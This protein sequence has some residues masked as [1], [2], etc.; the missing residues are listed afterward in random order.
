MALPP[1]YALMAAQPAA[2]PW[3]SSKQLA[4]PPPMPVAPP[5]GAVPP[6]A[7]PRVDPAAPAAGS[8]RTFTQADIDEIRRRGGNADHLVAGQP[9]AVTPAYTPGFQENVANLG[10]MPMNQQI[11]ENFIQNIRAR[12]AANAAAQVVFDYDPATGQMRPKNNYQLNPLGSQYDPNQWGSNN[13]LM[14]AAGANY[15]QGQGNKT[16]LPN[17]LGYQGALGRAQVAG[18]GVS[19]MAQQVPGSDLRSRG[20]QVGQLNQYGQ[21]IDMLRTSAQGG[22]PSAAANLMQSGLD[23]SI[24]AQMQ[25][26]AGARGGN[27][28]SANRAATQAGSQMQMQNTSQMAAMR[29]QE[30][31]QSQAQLAAANSQ[32]AGAFQG[33]RGQ[34]QAAGMNGVVAAAQAAQ[35]AQA[36]VGAQAGYTAAG[37]AQYGQGLQEQAMGLQYG[38]AGVQNQLGLMGLQ[39]QV[40]Q[41]AATGDQAALNAALQY[42]SLAQQGQLGWQNIATHVADTRYERDQMEAARQDAQIAAAAQGV[43]GLIQG[44]MQLY[45]GGGNGGYR[46]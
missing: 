46:A 17:Q 18:Q 9:Q 3:G 38:N 12:Q 1:N 5:P 6:A 34:D 11:P 42:Y 10:H 26:A 45:G 40:A 19:T 23:Q 4:A 41:A 30:Q 32:Y 2:N 7:P 39:A 15:A 8:T 20:Q 35:A 29:S 37:Q 16:A 36:N 43:G 31:L 14:G 25:M 28:A 33:L 22:G 13:A 44:G 21:D 24:R 27:V